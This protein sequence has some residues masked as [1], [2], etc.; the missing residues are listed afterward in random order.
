MTQIPP[1]VDAAT[2]LHEHCSLSATEAALYRN[3][4]RSGHFPRYRFSP[5][6]N[7]CTCIFGLL[8]TA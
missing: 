2:L 8:F 1:P 5:A 3:L 4:L 6:L 7:Q